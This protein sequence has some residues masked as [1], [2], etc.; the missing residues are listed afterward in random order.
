[1]NAHTEI[2]I[3]SAAPQFPIVYAMEVNAPNGAGDYQHGDLALFNTIEEPQAGDL[4]C[5]HPRKGGAVLVVLELGLGPNTWE[6]MPYRE[7]PESEVHALLIGTVLGTTRRVS[8]ACQDL[9]AVHKCDGKADP[10]D[11]GR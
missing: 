6:R 2:S 7:H 1:M 10:K 4:V 5:V 11:C 3:E 8:V 9:W